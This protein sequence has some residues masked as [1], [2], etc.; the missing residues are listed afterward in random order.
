MYLSYKYYF[1]E[2]FKKNKRL[3]PKISFISYLRKH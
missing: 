3:Y 1:I 2:L